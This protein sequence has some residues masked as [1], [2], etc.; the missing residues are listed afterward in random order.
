MP[1]SRPTPRKGF[2]K[3]RTGCITCKA[4]KVKCDE[5]QPHCLRC[6]STGRI[7]AG[8][9]TPPP[10]SFSWDN[11]LRVRPSTIPSASS[12]TELRGLDFFRCIVA[13][14]LTGPWGNSFWIRQVLQRAIQEEAT[15]QA[16]LA[17][18]SL[19]ERFDPLSYDSSFSDEHTVAVRYYNRALKQVATSKHLDA[20]A[21]L[22]LSILFTSIEFLRGNAK[23]AIEHCRHGI[24]I[25]K[26][27]KQ[28]S[29]D[30]SA[31]FHHL[32]VFPYFFGAT[33]SDFPLLQNLDYP[34][35]H[36]QNLS[37]AV[38]ILDC[39]LSSCVRL[40]RAF[41]PYRLGTVD[42]AKLPPLL[43][44]AQQEL[45]Q[46][47]DTWHAGFSTFRQGLESNDKNRSVYRIL[48]M[49]W[50]VCKIWVDIASYQDETFCDAYRDQFER[51]VEL[52]REE[53]AFREISGTAKPSV[54]QFEMGLSPLLHFVVIKC[55]FLKLRLE[56]WALQK[57]L[58]CAR[59]SLWDAALMYATN[60][61]IIEREHGIKLDPQLIERRLEGIGLDCTLPSDIQRVRDSYLEDEVQHVEYGGSRMTRRR[62]CLFV[63][64]AVGNVVEIVQDWIYVPERS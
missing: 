11:L 58:A 34:N 5:N 55:R 37:Q 63:R 47:L 59:E 19:Y 21:V 64:P 4:R 40:V 28:A 12:S 61:C 57:T 9:R 38:E 32:S 36:I 8:Y 29:S 51:I 20:D 2:E 39:L 23:A 60:R 53:A 56:A 18:S 13:P 7:C 31:I 48:E 62:I 46:E 30:M 49:R 1:D 44:V 45:R 54:F 10:G 3:V 26:T 42:V 50:L 24:H 22:F 27:T 6:R 16:V 41:D 15:R 52:A 35:H 14:A 17:I 33:P 43:I 25:L